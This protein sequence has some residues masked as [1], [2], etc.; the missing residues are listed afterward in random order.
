MKKIRTMV[1]ALAL[2]A[3]II[4]GCYNDQRVVTVYEDEYP[5]G[6]NWFNVYNR[7]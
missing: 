6:A 5:P 7:R 1:F 2:V 4:S 3:L